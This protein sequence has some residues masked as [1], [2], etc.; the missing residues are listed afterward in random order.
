[1]LEDS[2]VHPPQGKE[3]SSQAQ[4]KACPMVRS[5]WPIQSDGV[6]WQ[7]HVSNHAKDDQIYNY[8]T[9]C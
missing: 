2:F 1:M 6:G 4:A 5:N 3:W 7:C 8:G 9:V